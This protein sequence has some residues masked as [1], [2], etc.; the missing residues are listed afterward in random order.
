METT[1]LMNKGWINPISIT[2][3]LILLHYCPLKMDKVKN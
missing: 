1:N 2:V 3:F